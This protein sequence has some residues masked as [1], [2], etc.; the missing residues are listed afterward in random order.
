VQLQLNDSSCES[1]EVRLVE[2]VL[3]HVKRFIIEQGQTTLSIFVKNEAAHLFISEIK[4]CLT[5]L[6]KNSRKARFQIRSAVSLSEKNLAN[7]FYLILS[8]INK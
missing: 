3:E 5:L 1:D 8:C 7:L 4:D 2:C 6:P